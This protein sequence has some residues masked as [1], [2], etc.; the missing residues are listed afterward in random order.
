M[1]VRSP[2]THTTTHNLPH[3]H[4]ISSKHT[5]APDTRQV[6]LPMHEHSGAV[7]PAALIRPAKL[8]LLM[9]VV[10]CARLCRCGQNDA[11]DSTGR[12]RLRFVHVHVVFVMRL[13]KDDSQNWAHTPLNKTHIF[14]PLQC[15][16][17]NPLPFSTKRV[18]WLPLKGRH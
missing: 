11:R 17:S 1:A 8:L 3:P 7:C 10:V 2:S 12:T 5:S 9:L 15:G 6:Y 18:V 13:G 16:A 4:K 14:P